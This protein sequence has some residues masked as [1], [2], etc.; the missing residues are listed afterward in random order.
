MLRQLQDFLKQRGQACLADIAAH[1]KVDEAVA[2]SMLR[3]LESRGRVR[4]ITM[5]A[6]LCGGCTRCAPDAREEWA[7]TE[8]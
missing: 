8:R 1:L 7:L 6:R 3:L 4:R 5:N 2:L